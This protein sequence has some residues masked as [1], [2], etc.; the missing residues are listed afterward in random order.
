MLLNITRIWVQRICL[1][2]LVL[3]I[4]KFIFDVWVTPDYKGQE[5]YVSNSPNDQY[6]ALIIPTASSQTVLILQRLDN[7]QYVLITPLPSDWVASLSDDN[8]ICDKENGCTAYRAGYRPQ[9]S[10]PPSFRLRLHAW[11]TI[12]IKH[13][14]N[15]QLKEIN[16]DE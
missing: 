7:Q 16:R 11:L 6:K 5:A 3:L 15:P 13:L 10:L 12:K 2:A 1:I 14:K 4:L 8:W 9:F